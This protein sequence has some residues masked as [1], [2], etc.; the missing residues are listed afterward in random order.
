MD[1]EYVDTDHPVDDGL[2]QRLVVDGS[3]DLVH[4]ARIV[5]K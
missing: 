4:C 5:P 3:D 1:D 2:K